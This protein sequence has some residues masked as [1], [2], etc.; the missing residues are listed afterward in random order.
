MARVI[1][2]EQKE[3]KAR[4]GKIITIAASVV[5][6]L[7]AIG[8]IVFCIFALVDNITP[9]LYKNSRDMDYETLVEMMDD[10]T[11]R[12]QYEGTIYILVFNSDI[13]E[14]P[15]Y[16]LSSTVDSRVNDA[17]KY[18]LKLNEYYD[19]NGH[20][21]EN[22]DKVAFYVIDLMDSENEG[23]LSDVDFGNDSGESYLIELSNY[24]SNKV[25]ITS[26]S[27]LASRLRSINE[28]FSSMI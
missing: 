7:A 2:K 3:K 4:N 22:K 5:G 14:Y 20:S 18:D 21:I 10:V 23:I 28:T 19:K 25:S 24:T 16:E 8:L 11:T 13:E 15:S 12:Q 9:R 27:N 1:K 6:G 17:I 26:N